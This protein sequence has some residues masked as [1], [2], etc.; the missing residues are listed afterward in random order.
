MAAFFYVNFRRRSIEN[1]QKNV[2]QF[3]AFSQREQS[4][5]DVLKRY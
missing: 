5:T 1:V 3:G 2:R 4:A